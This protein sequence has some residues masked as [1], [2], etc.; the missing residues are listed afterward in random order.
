MLRNYI[1]E[2]LRK[3]DYE[4]IEVFKKYLLNLIGQWTELTPRNQ[5]GGYVWDS[6]LV[7]LAGDDMGFCDYFNDFVSVA[8]SEEDKDFLK[9]LGIKEHNA[10]NTY[11]F[12]DF[13]KC[14]YDDLEGVLEL[15]KN[16]LIL[17]LVMQSIDS[18][19][20]SEL[21]Y[22][23]YEDLEGFYNEIANNKVPEIS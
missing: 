1:I 23:L 16:A 11:H 17:K 10:F 13:V 3:S 20:V 4:N 21:D 22:I 19:I 8:V 15:D 6:D 14:F 12:N 2:E 7:E 9:G 5:H 18:Y